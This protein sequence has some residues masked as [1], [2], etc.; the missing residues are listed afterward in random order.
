MRLCCGGLV[1]LALMG[2]GRDVPSVPTEVDAWARRV[3]A[4][5]VQEACVAG[6]TDGFFCSVRPTLLTPEVRRLG[7][8]IT[9]QNLR[10]E[11]Y[12]NIDWGG[13][14][15]EAYGVI[16]GPSGWTHRADPEFREH[17]IRD[18]VFSYDQRQ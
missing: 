11:R 18:G 8:T 1:V 12:I 2:C 4:L 7:A 9:L 10:G 14:H 17:R 13:G 5:P 6:Q 3:I 16:I 15:V